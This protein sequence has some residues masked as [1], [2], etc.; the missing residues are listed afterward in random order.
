MELRAFLRPDVL[1]NKF[2]AIKGY[3]ES[4]NRDGSPSLKLSISI[5]DENSDFF[6][7]LFTVKVNNNNPTISV[8]ELK[9]NKSREVVLSDLR[10]N[11]FNDKLWFSCAD[12]LPVAK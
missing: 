5:Q 1:G 10:I 11:Y 2:Y 3:V 6:M 9:N 7:E 4:L 12:I 8:N